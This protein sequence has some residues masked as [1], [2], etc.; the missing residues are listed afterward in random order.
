MSRRLVD[1]IRKIAKTKE[2]E[3]RIKLVKPDTDKNAIGINRGTG[4]PTEDE[5]FATCQTLYSGENGAYAF[6][7]IVD[8]TDEP[9]IVDGGYNACEQINTIIDM[10]ECGD[11]ALDMYLKPDGV[12]LDLDNTAGTDGLIWTSNYALACF[13]AVGE[14]TGMEAPDLWSSATAE[15]A[16]DKLETLLGIFQDVPGNISGGFAGAVA[17]DMGALEEVSLPSDEWPE[18]QTVYKIA[19][20]EMGD[21]TPIYYYYIFAIPASYDPRPTE[22]EYNAVC[23]EDSYD[24][25]LDSLYFP[26]LDYE[27]GD[28]LAVCSAGSLRGTQYLQGITKPDLGINAFQLALNATTGLWTPNAGEPFPVKYTQGVNIVKV[29]F[30]DG[31][32]GLVRPAKDGGFMLYE[33]D[34]SDVPVGYARVYRNNRTLVAIVPVA[35][36][37]FYLP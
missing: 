3:S 6:E 23:S 1:N 32:M 11:E 15:D 13:Y 4:Y 35:Q 31:R 33:I 25:G 9:G 37:G 16:K 34:I 22:A 8:G 24:S 36:L 19:V 29:C 30:G 10:N 17:F 7:D 21:P 20:N 18:D 27:T 12:Y 26:N 2:L 5:T 28:Y 14:D